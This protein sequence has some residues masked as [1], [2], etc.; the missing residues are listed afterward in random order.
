[1]ER[2]LALDK[3]PDGAGTR[4]P[5]LPDDIP[6][7]KDAI[8]RMSA[9]LVI[10]DPIMAFLGADTNSH[11]DQDV[12]RA[13]HPLAVMAQETGAAVLVVRHLNKTAGGNPLYRGGG[14]IGI[15]GAARSGLLVAREPDN[16]DHRVLAST[17]CNLAK[18]PASLSFD[19]STADNGALRVGWIGESSHTAE[20]LL[21]APKDD[22]ERDAVKEAVDVLRTLLCNG[23][24][25]A[26]DVKRE[27][28]KAGVALRTLQRAKAALHVQA[29]LIGFGKDG[30]WFWSLP[31][32]ANPEG[33]AHSGPVPAPEESKTSE[34]PVFLQSAPSSPEV[35]K[36]KSVPSD[37]ALSAEPERE[38]STK[39]SQ[40][41]ARLQ[42]PAEE[43]AEWTA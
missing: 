9:K 1:V 32:I 13:L 5:V 3:I 31:E 36:N 39:P 17:K 10:I 37:L 2:V 16:P 24:R 38:Q 20:S 25:W 14:S 40:D 23:S 30:K 22:E 42:G 29:S 18:L 26:E 35:A 6:H 28:R 15:I 4:L 19:L 7:I 33:L 11:R 43:E 27:A 12:R 8:L 21:A 41:A 34:S